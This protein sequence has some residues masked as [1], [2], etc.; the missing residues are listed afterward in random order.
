MRK[1]FY[2]CEK[3]SKKLIERLPNGIWKFA[4]GRQRK[5]VDEFGE[6]V[7]FDKELYEPAVILLIRGSIKMK[8]LR[9]TCNHDNILPHFPQSTDFLEDS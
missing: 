1:N 6:P 3:C 4:F 7:P 8:C 5:E 9:K 2:R